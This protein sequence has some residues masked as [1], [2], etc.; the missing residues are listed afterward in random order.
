MEKKGKMESVLEEFGGK[1]NSILKKT[2]PLHILRKILR[3]LL[4]EG[5]FVRKWVILWSTV[6]NKIIIGD[7]EFKIMVIIC[8]V[9][10][11]IELW[12]NC[13]KNEFMVNKIW[14][15]GIEWKIEIMWIKMKALISLQ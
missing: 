14:V 6:R 11:R 1:I 7:F 5:G 3:I 9:W 2:N 13:Y 8:N 15:M 12:V 4:I 10:N